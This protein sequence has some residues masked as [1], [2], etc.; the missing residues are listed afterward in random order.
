MTVSQLVHSSL[1]IATV[2][3][4]GLSASAQETRGPVTLFNGKDLTGWT[5]VLD[6]KDSDPAKTWSV[7]NG[8]LKCT[9]QPAGYIK[10][11]KEYENYILRLEWRWPKGAKGGNN[12]VLIHSTTPGALGVWPRSIEVQL[13]QD[14]AGDFWVI[15]DDASIKIPDQAKRQHGRHH[16]N[17]TDGSEKP[18]GEW[19][20]ME[21][22]SHDGQ[23]TVKVNGTLVNEGTDS[24]ERKGAISLQS[25]G[26]PIEFR[27]ITL[28]PLR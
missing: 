4:I 21:I 5:P 15:P 28:E 11:D 3:G 26:A 9:G 27:N 2:A 25:E 18:T 16:A 19:N 7:E 6:P 10:T 1:L 8:I 24:S 14:N 12:G 13:A 23:V 20:Q 22:T 17:L